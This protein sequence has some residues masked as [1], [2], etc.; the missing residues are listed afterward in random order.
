MPENIFGE[1]SFEQTVKEKGFNLSLPTRV[2][3]HNREGNFF[4]EKTSL[5]YISHQGA[6]FWLRTPISIGD[7]LKLTVDLPPKLSQDQDLKLIIR[8]AVIFVEAAT[9]EIPKQRVSIKFE[10]KYIIE[11][12]D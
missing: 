7:D 2:E 5:S 1:K 8:G 12:E 6:S 4:N 11:N 9:N 3:G 10:N